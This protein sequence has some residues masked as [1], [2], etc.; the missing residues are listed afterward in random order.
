MTRFVI[1]FTTLFLLMH[2]TTIAL[3]KTELHDQYGPRTFSSDR[4]WTAIVAA[5]EPEIKAINHAFSQS[6]DAEIT[7]IVTFKRIVGFLSRKL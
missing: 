5:Y 7:K 6:E 1:R 3:A 4:S 2:I